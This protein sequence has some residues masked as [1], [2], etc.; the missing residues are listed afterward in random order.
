M[1][2]QLLTLVFATKGNK[3]EFNKPIKWMLL[4]RE[5]KDFRVTVLDFLKKA[6]ENFD[7]RFNTKTLECSLILMLYIKAIKVWQKDATE[8]LWPDAS[9]LSDFIRICRRKRPYKLL[10]EAILAWAS[11]ISLNMK[12][13]LMDIQ[14]NES[15]FNM[16]TVG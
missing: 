16:S 14:K 2:L 13:T 3:E 12:Q 8:F 10:A 7:N 11:K 5:D 15:S 6:L 9:V 4:D 1:F